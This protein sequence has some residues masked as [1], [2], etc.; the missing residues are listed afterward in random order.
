M[1]QFAFFSCMSEPT[2]T[3]WEVAAVGRAVPCSSKCRTAHCCRSSCGWIP[4]VPSSTQPPK[5][6]PQ[7]LLQN[8]PF[9]Q[10]CRKARTRVHAN[11][12][13]KQIR[14]TWK[15]GLSSWLHSVFSTAKLPVVCWWRN[16]QALS[17]QRSSLSPALFSCV[18]HSPVSVRRWLPSRRAFVE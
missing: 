6:F 3:P 12:F 18:R 13:W 16:T 15:W 8:S 1:H 17:A 4:A 5:V 11:K 14:N 2:S 9:S 10:D 7:A